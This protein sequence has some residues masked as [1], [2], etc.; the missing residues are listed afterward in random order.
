M[1]DIVFISG[2]PESVVAAAL[3]RIGYKVLHLDRCVKEISYVMN[4][5]P[6]LHP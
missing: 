1:N 2:L 6:H 5:C 3:S 4:V